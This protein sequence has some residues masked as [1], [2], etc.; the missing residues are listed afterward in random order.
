MSK[1]EPETRTLH[2]SI[3]GRIITQIAREKL[4]VNNDLKGAFETIMSS[5]MTDQLTEAQHACIALA[6]LD[7]RKEIVGVYPGDT[8]GIEDVPED[9]RPN[10]NITDHFAKMVEK[11]A[12][13]ERKNK[14]LLDK[15]ACVSE[16]IGSETLLR[17]CDAEWRTNWCDKDAA[18]EDRTIFSTEKSYDGTTE[19]ILGILAED[20][21]MNPLQRAMLPQVAEFTQRMTQSEDL[22]PDYGWLFPDGRF[23]PVEFGDHLSWAMKWLKKH[24]P[25]WKDHRAMMEHGHDF[26]DAGDVLNRKY[27]AVLLH[28]PAMGYALIT[29]MNFTEMTKAQKEFLYDYYIKRGLNDKANEVWRED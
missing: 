8:Y 26:S 5:T 28:N 1:P 11:M 24:D 16:C 27:K 7:G 3:T 2:F 9:K 14:V 20:D 29:N 17:R 6:I 21:D 12:E 23:E 15:L 4:Y 19:T 25:E 13:L 18:A 10:W 22:E